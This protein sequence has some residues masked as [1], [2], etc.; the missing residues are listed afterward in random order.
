MSFNTKLRSLVNRYRERH[1]K[2]TSSPTSGARYIVTY[3]FDNGALGN[4]YPGILSAFF[5][6][7]LTNRTLLI[8][9]GN[10]LS[11]LEHD[12]V[13]FRYSEQVS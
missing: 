13:D 3:E 11:H 2:A 5:L 4:S 7:L 1:R 10:A 8:D 12:D 6:A 9:D